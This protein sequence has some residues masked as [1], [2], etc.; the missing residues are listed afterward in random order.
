LQWVSQ[1]SLL[2]A[3]KNKA[4][5]RSCTVV[6]ALLNIEEEGQQEEAKVPSIHE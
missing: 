1:G 3:L 6:D 5:D 4:S 2:K